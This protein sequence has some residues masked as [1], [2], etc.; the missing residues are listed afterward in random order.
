MTCAKMG[1]IGRREH[2]I[3]ALLSGRIKAGKGRL[4]GEW[5]EVPLEMIHLCIGSQ[6][7][8]VRRSHSSKK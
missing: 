2:V 6:H 4:K 8:A 3:E 7:G 1:I 5:L